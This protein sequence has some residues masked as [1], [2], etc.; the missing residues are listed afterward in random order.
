MNNINTKNETLKT[1]IDLGSKTT[2]ILVLSLQK[3][4]R[5]IEGV[6]RG[7]VDGVKRFT[8]PCR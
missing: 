7:V 2:R 5:D 8:L 6:V 4:F 3:R 1:K